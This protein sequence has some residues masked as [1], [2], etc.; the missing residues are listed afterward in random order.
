MAVDGGTTPVLRPARDADAAACGAI[1]QGWL[2]A[3]DWMPDL[4]DLEETIGFCGRLIAADDVTVADD[5][6]VRGF[7]ARRGEDI[8]A[9]YVAAQARGRGVGSALIG[10]AQAASER[11][12]L[13]TFQANTDARRFYGRHGFVEV[14]R[15]EGDNDE[16]L[17]DIRLAWERGRI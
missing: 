12:E 2:D 11:L 10:A 4:H 7:L 15:T 6:S 13:W 3:T 14:R 8:P 9:L 1:L 16:G 17:P 5:G